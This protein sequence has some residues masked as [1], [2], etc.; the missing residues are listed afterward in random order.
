MPKGHKLSKTQLDALRWIGA[1]PSHESSW[2]RNGKLAY[3]P[4]STWDTMEVSGSRG[5]IRIS[6]G[7]WQAIMDYFEVAPQAS[8]SMW[9]LNEAGK[10]AIGQ[11]N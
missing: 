4:P 5:T 6:T 1:F 2:L 7:D 10:K 8:P 11:L 3:G 9:Q